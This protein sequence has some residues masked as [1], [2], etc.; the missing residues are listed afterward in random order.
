MA[1]LDAEIA[2]AQATGKNLDSKTL[3][4]TLKAL[5]VAVQ[6]AQA[7]AMTPGVTPVADEL[8]ASAGFVD[9]NGSDQTIDP[10]SV[11]EQIQPAT[12][13]PDPRLGDGA[14]TGIQTTT[15]VDNMQ[16]NP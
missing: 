9:A 16:P 5:Y 3:A 12:P 13:L 14:A 8:L 15:G 10:A 1:K 11:P 7:V 6:A 4:E 2:T